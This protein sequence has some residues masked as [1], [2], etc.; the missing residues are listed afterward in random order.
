MSEQA[1]IDLSF[2]FEQ[3]SF[4][5]DASG[6]TDYPDY[7]SIDDWLS[8]CCS[9]ILVLVWS[10]LEKD[11]LSYCFSYILVLV[12]AVLEKDSRTLLPQ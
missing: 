2:Y 11:W 5:W 9:Y 8:Y 4:D 12:W 10:V 6:S 7:N 3:S 1:N